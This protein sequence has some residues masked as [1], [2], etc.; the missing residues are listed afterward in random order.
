LT[1]L[2]ALAQRFPRFNGRTPNGS[3][4]GDARSL[5]PRAFSLYWQHLPAQ[6][7]PRAGPTRVRALDN[8]G[9]YQDDIGSLR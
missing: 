5:P 7:P 4:V 1:A 3:S 9:E 8:T 2:R 6:H